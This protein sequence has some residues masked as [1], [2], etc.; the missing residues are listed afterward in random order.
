MV[1]S[2]EMEKMDNFSNSKASNII[3]FWK[4]LENCNKREDDILPISASVDVENESSHDNNDDIVVQNKISRPYRRTFSRGR[5]MS[6]IFTISVKQRRQFFEQIQ[7]GIEKK[8]IVP[9]TIVEEQDMQGSR[10]DDGMSIS[11]K[12]SRPLHL[13]RTNYMDNKTYSN[14]INDLERKNETNSRSDTC[15]PSDIQDDDDQTSKS[16]AVSAVLNSIVSKDDDNTERRE[17]EEDVK[18][19]F[20]I[21]QEDAGNEILISGTSALAGELDPKLTKKHSKRKTKKSKKSAKSHNHAG[22]VIRSSLR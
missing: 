17:A 1:S 15:G 20:S 18:E 13:Q 16:L 2:N 3:D 4:K 10:D 7:K 22:K 19:T 5:P 9:T 21:K 8:K 11:R 14:C 6:R 12:S